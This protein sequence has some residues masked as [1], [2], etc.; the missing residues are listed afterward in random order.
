M[1]NAGIVPYSP[2]SGRT[3]DSMTLLVASGRTAGTSITLL[4]CRYASLRLGGPPAVSLVLTSC[5]RGIASQ[6]EADEA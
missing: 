6:H 4:H 2:A 5:P 1:V 3:A